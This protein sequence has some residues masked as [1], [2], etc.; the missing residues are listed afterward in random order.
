MDVS[1]F[2]RLWVE[3]TDCRLLVWI[4][5]LSASSWGC[6]LKFALITPPETS[7]SSASSW[8][9]ELK[10]KNIVLPMLKW[11]Q[12]LREA[13]SWN[14]LLFVHFFS[15]PRQ[16]LREA[17]SW[18]TKILFFRCWN[19]SS[20]SSWGCELKCFWQDYSRYSSLSASSWGCELKSKY[21]LSSCIYCRQPL[22]EAVSWNVRIWK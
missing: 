1:L 17:V 14:I 9:C 20:A 6:E 12:P 22:R 10:Y 7:I 19:G 11:G 2:V 4:R 3:I 16:P 18:N 13:V 15:T 8:G 5:L 21:S